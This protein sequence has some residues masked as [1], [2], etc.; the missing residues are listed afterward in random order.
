VNAH[1]IAAGTP[2]IITHNARQYVEIVRASVAM[3]GVY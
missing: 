2:E 1:A 3:Q